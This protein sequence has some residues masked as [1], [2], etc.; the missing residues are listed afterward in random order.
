[1]VIA[2]AMAIFTAAS[3]ALASVVSV[4]EVFESP[5]NLTIGQTT[6]GTRTVDGQTDGPFGF[7][8]IGGDPVGIGA[9]SLTNGA[10]TSSTGETFGAGPGA[11]IGING[12]GSLS[13]ASGSSWSSTGSQA[14][15]FVGDGATGI[16]TISITGAGTTL[17]LG[18]G[19]FPGL[20]VGNN[21]FGRFNA[22]DGAA[23]SSVGDL[24][25][26]NRAG[27]FGVGRIGG[28]GT[29]ID[30]ARALIVGFGGSGTLTVDT[31][32]HVDARRLLPGVSANFGG[33]ISGGSGTITLNGAGTLLT[34]KD[35]SPFSSGGVFQNNIPVG[36]GAIGTVSVAG[37]AQLDI[38]P[39]VATHQGSI[40][41]GGVNNGLAGTGTLTVG[42]A[43]SEI[44]IRGNSTAGS[45]LVGLLTVGNGEASGNFVTPGAVHIAN[46][47]KIFVD[48][49]PANPSGAVA[50]I[51]RL[52]GGIG[53]LTLN[54]TDSLLQVA[55][56]LTVG[57]KIA[58]FDP[59]AA[60]SG[61]GNV[62]VSSG[63]TI[64][65]DRVFIGN[66]TMVAAAGGHVV[67][68]LGVVGQLAG[69]I[70]STTLTGADAVWAL[71]GPLPPGS[72]RN[73]LTVGSFG[74]ASLNV[75]NGA[76]L[77]VDGG[78]NLGP[79]IVLG[80]F[81]GGSGVL[82]V[83]GVGS[84]V[85]LTGVG[86]RTIPDPLTPGRFF[87]SGFNVGD[88]GGGALNV[89]GGGKVALTAVKVGTATPE[90][91]LQIGRDPG[92]TGTALVSGAGSEISAHTV[93]V[94]LDPDDQPGGTGVLTVASGGTLTVSGDLKIGPGG[95]V[96][97]D[98]G[99]IVGNVVNM[100][101][102]ISPGNS[103]GTL[104]IVGSYTHLAGK[105][106]LEISGT[107]SHD[108]LAV[109]GAA[110]FP[111]G[112]QIEVRMDPTYHPA[113]GASLPL[114][115]VQAT[116]D[117]AP[118]PLLT[119][120]VSESGSPTVQAEGSLAS[121]SQPI[122][123]VPDI[124]I[125][126]TVRAVTIDVKP[127]EFPNVVNL[128][129][130]GTMPVAILSTVAFDALT[131]DPST[132]RLNGAAVKL[133]GRGQRSLCRPEDVNG[134]DRP[135]LVCRIVTSDVS[136]TGESVVVL[137]AMTFPAGQAAGIPVRGA[138]FIR[139]VPHHH[140]HHHHHEEHSHRSAAFGFH[141]A[142]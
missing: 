124:T 36:F 41:V 26:G 127:N 60:D 31:G 101:G 71:T 1:M 29:T 9:Y 82:N 135:D 52:A 106:V 104:S 24:V 98:G 16:G 12:I 134:D 137:D 132:I 13:L 138:D 20:V 94:G 88:Q 18:G 75:L 45:T 118:Q 51:G 15:V 133:T 112:T 115:Q 70:A 139:V 100:G 125:P 122:V 40:S 30:V 97:G 78:A 49:T 5:S 83:S 126:P 109:E 68:A 111:P 17:S 99:T 58:G 8:G 79:A 72:S 25:L 48:D 50:R 130:K 131:I 19:S 105:I 39:N 84:F 42:G 59:A 141:H 95:T 69:E 87:G 6:T 34:L 73:A 116:P 22:A 11:I 77:V 65:A 14:T 46:G 10:A 108:V 121:L 142:R 120:A 53:T 3:P 81:A 113:G 67:S 114:L 44:H 91:G 117:G 136:L 102:V 54:G 43:G 86:D 90:N 129:S 32:A 85:G 61:A 123:V 128:H 57:Q 37:G 21:G 23:A 103:P 47:G 7:I 63:A 66:G 76:Q 55:G 74:S 64:D 35:Q 62:R 80:R 28:V 89:T 96:N 92:S 27:S 119:V 93:R 2:T 38:A 107:G 140:H 110:A 56:N 4:G 33:V